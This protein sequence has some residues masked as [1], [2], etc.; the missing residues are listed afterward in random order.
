[1]SVANETTAGNT[2]WG[3]IGIIDLLVDIRDPSSNTEAEHVWGPPSVR[4][5]PQ[6]QSPVGYLFK[7]RP[8]RFLEVDEIL[9]EMDKYGVERALITLEEGNERAYRAARD[10][11]D[12]FFTSIF[13]DPNLGMVEVFRI[14]RAYDELGIKAVVAFPSGY[15]PAVPIN[16][17]KMYP[18]YAKCVE[19][20][21]PICVTAGVPGPLA[22]YESQNV[23][24]IDEVCWF[25]PDLKFVVRHGGEPWTALMCKLLLK[26]PNLYYSTSAFA[27]RYYPADIVQLANSRA[28]DKV[29][30]A[31]YFPVGM[32]LERIFRELAEVPFKP[33][34]WA[35][36]LRDN[37]IRVFKLDG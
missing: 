9:A 18:I 30:Y 16:D 21:L 22:P 7:A 10:H 4:P 15:T 32:T 20:D 27:P 24:L 28:P 13:V 6:G 8:N 14:V 2:P 35:G 12:R 23:G 3:D 5:A 33:E 19:L 36:F 29:M 1:V 34:V 26:W 25:F 11:P 17:K 37:A 31:G